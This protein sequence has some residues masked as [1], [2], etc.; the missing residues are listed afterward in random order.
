MV[1]TSTGLEPYFS[2]SYTREGRL[3]IY[4]E[5]VPLV[6]EYHATHPD[7]TSLP[8]YFVTAMELTPEQHVRVQATF[9]RWIDSA[10][11]KTCNV[12]NDYTVEQVGQLY[13]YMYDLGCKGGTVYRD[14]SRD[15]QVLTQTTVPTLKLGN[16]CPSC[17][18]D[19]LEAESGCQRC[20]NPDCGYTACEVM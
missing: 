1:N 15:I 18:Q 13:E 2:W 19:T 7:A 10:I 20:I 9:Q 5:H 3:G 6:E 12:P 17:L 16:V 8:D 11:S 4:T 14:G